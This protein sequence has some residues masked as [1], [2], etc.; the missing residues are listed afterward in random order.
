MKGKRKIL[1]A[2][3]N[4]LSKRF[5]WSMEVAR[6]EARKWLKTLK[7]SGYTEDFQLSI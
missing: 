3:A 7:E 2:L 6:E 5:G 1:D 4:E